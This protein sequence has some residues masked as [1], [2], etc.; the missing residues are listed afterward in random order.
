[1][2]IIDD[3]DQIDRWTAKRKLE[4]VLR[5]LRGDVSEEQLCQ[6]YGVNRSEYRKWKEKVLK[7]G[8][9]ALVERSSKDPQQKEIERLKKKVGELTVANDV[10]KK[11]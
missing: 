6:E 4:L 1:M 8:Q 11:T 9:E 3:P 10:L 2:S 7:K 5:G